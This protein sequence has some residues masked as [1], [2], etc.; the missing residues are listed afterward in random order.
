MVSTNVIRLA[1]L[2]I[3]LAIC[4]A[5]NAVGFR[6]FKPQ[7]LQYKKCIEVYGKP[8]PAN[9][10]GMYLLPSPGY[11]D[12]RRQFK[13]DGK[14]FEAK[15]DGVHGWPFG[16]DM[17]YS[18]IIRYA[19]NNDYLL[20][21]NAT[22]PGITDGY[23]YMTLKHSRWQVVRRFWMFGFSKCSFNAASEEEV[24]GIE[25]VWIEQFKWVF[26]FGMTLK[27]NPSRFCY[28]IRSVT[29]PFCRSLPLNW[30]SE[31]FTGKDCILSLL[32]LQSHIY[33]RS[34][35]K[36]VSRVYPTLPL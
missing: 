9:I 13:H 30:R 25:Q 14:T 22:G 19:P 11:I 5:S 23:Y 7:E 10:M 15:N 29:V 2:T 32:F 26:K 4:H 18:A 17:K 27:I 6:G 20:S 34:P 16:K 12:D 28:P 36:V 8:P 33:C 21:I 35:I 24:K 31:A 1:Y 3:I